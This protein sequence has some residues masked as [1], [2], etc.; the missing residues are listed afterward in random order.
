MICPKCEREQPDGLDECMRCGVI[1]SRIVSTSGNQNPMA[2]DWSIFT[3]GPKQLFGTILIVGIIGFML[4]VL[5]YSSTESARQYGIK[6][7]TPATPD[8]Y[9]DWRQKDASAEAIIMMEG[10][11]KDRL[12]APGSADFKR[13]YTDSVTR[14]AGQKYRIISWVDAQN[15]FGAKLRNHFIG[16]VEQTKKGHWQLNSL[17][18]SHN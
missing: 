5:A 6:N 11:V 14:L 18:F 12:K 16:E 7:A 13:G 10:F 9:I 3:G 1:F 8:A 15:S 17:E 4:Y 2:R